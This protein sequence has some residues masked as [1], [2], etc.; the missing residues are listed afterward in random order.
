M[1]SYH[2][3]APMPTTI[4][5]KD[6]SG[7]ADNIFCL[8]KGIPFLPS[9]A[10]S[11]LTLVYNI[12]FFMQNIVLYYTTTICGHYCRHW[13]RILSVAVISSMVFPW[14]YK[15]TLSFLSICTK[16]DLYVN[17]SFHWW[18][19]HKSSQKPTASSFINYH[20]HCLCLL[21]LWYDKLNKL[22]QLDLYLYG[23][24][25]DICWY[26]CIWSMAMIVL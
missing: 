20:L 16:Y 9:S 26:L 1:S 2:T 6:M 15:N 14:S 11:Q 3:N 8:V 25:V 24:V 5:L 21:L 12:I 18:N 23:Y 19:F 22:P 4:K 17:D 10:L 7:L 13:W